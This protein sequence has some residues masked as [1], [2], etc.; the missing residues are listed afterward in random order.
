VHRAKHAVS[1]LISELHCLAHSVLVAVVSLSRH[2]YAA[3]SGG[4]LLASLP[5]IL[6]SDLSYPFPDVFDTGTD[7]KGRLILLFSL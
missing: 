5:C 6:L 3:V 1:I 7:V 4:L 2:A